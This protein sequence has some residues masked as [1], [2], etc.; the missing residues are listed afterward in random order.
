MMGA[1][2]NRYNVQGTDLFVKSVPKVGPIQVEIT[3]PS[4]EKGC[5]GIQ[6]HNPKK[7]KKSFRLTKPR[8]EEVKFV[9]ALAE[10]I[11]KPLLRGLLTG[12]INEAGLVKL[13][14][15]QKV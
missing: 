11:V 14:M 5:A 9:T 10:D 7:G 8:K 2:R 4:G 3:T 15:K 6:F 13:Q 1:V 12:D